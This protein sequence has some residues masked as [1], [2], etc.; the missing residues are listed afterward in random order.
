M[1]L[2]LD[3]TMSHLRTDDLQNNLNDRNIMAR[4]KTVLG[5]IGRANTIEGINTHWQIEN[6]NLT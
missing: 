4:S 3:E 2:L 1:C 6:D 5:D